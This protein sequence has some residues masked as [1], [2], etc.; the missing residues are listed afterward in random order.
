VI[1]TDFVPASIVRPSSGLVAAREG[2]QVDLVVA[3]HAPSIGPVDET[4]LRTR[5]GSVEAMGTVPPT[6]QMP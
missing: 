5:P 1:A 6:S 4:A 2:E 3:R